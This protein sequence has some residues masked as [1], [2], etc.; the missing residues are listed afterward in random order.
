MQDN[1]SFPE[2]INEFHTRNK[3]WHRHASPLS[4]LLLGTLMALALC[5]LFGGQSHPRRTVETSAADMHLQ[6]PQRLR[7]GEFFEMRFK[8]ET[9]RPFTDLTLAISSAYWK[10]LTINT[11]IP[12]PSEEKSERGRYLFSYGPVDA[13][14]VLNIK[15]DGQINPPLFAGTRGEVT[16][17]DGD[18]E[19]ARVPVKLRVYP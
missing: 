11:M 1:A 17:L 5:G 13:G 18:T 4:I 12:A 10:D 7:N 14:E 2:G 9:K 8:V 3:G 16:L 19:I 6:L 15:F